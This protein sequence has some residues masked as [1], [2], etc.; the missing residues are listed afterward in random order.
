[1]VNLV[2]PPP[3]LQAD[4]LELYYV[5]DDLLSRSPILIFYG[6]AATPAASV[7]NNSR[8]QAHI[9]SPA[10][11]QSFHRLS[12][13]PGSPLYSAVQCLPRE[14]QGDEICRGLAFSLFKYFTELP[15][16]A[17]QAWE[18]QPT[19]LGSMRS[20]P[21]LF[22]DAHAGILASRMVRVENVAEVLGDVTQALAEQS[23][24]WLDLDI[25]L[26]PGTTKPLEMG[27]RDSILPQPSDEDIAGHRYGAYAPLIK[28]FGEVAFLPT[29]RLKRAPSKPTALNRK[30]TFT[31]EQ[32]EIV[33]RE[34]VDLLDSEERYVEKIGE[35]VHNVASDFREKARTKRVSSNS[36]NSDALQGLFPES[37]DKILETNNA[38]LEAMRPIVDNTVDE[39]IA[40]IE[41]TPEGGTVMPAVPTRADVTGTLAL[42]TCLRSWFPKFADCY[43]DYTL[44]HKQFTTHLRSFMK[45]SNSSFSR[46]IQDTGEQRLMSMLIEPVQR[47]PRYNLYIDNII[48]QLPARHPALNS[49]LK[50]RDTIAEICS[51]DHTIA[52]PSRVHDNLRAV[53]SAW[54][55]TFSPKGRL[56]SAVDIIELPPPYRPDLN[57][58]RSVPGILLLFTDYIVILRKNSKQSMTARGLL[59]QLDGTDVLASE[60]ADVMVD[61]LSFRQTLELNT[62]D[63]TEMDSG[64]MVQLVPLADTVK[65]PLGPRR[66]GSSRPASLSGESAVQVFYLSGT[67][68][69]KA[70]RLIEDLV[71]ARVEGRF[72]EEERDSHKWEARSATCAD[73][74]LLGALFEKEQD[75][76]PAGRGAPARVR[77]LI[78][79][80]PSPTL[81]EMAQTS[82]HGMDAIASLTAM[83]DGYYC[84]RVRQVGLAAST[85]TERL[86]AQECLPVLVTFCK[87]C[88]KMRCNIKHPAMAATFLLRNQHI[89]QSMR[90]LTEESHEHTV[91]ERASRPHSPVKML[92]NLFGGSVSRDHGSLRKHT[93]PIPQM[94]PTPASRP[95][96]EDGPAKAQP[97]SPTQVVHTAADALIRLEETLAS[98][99][100]ALD[101][102][103]GNI[104]GRILRGRASADELMVNELYNAL[105]EDPANYEIVAQSPIDVLFSAFEKF[106]KVAWYEKIG[107]IISRSTWNAIQSKMDTTYPGDFE[108][109]FR[110][111]YGEMSPQNQRALRACIKLLADLLGGTSNDSDRGVLT[112]SFAEVLVR[113]GNPNEFI[114]VLDR[115]VEDIQALLGEQGPSAQPTPQGSMNEGSRTQATNTGSL[116]S[117]TSLRKKFG[118]GTLTRKAS[119]LGQGDESE[120]GEKSEKTDLAS[121][122][123]AL[124]K[125]KHGGETSS[126]SKASMGNIGRS[127]STDVNARLSPKRP[128]SRDRPTVL[129]AFA[130]EHHNSPLTTIGEGQKAS[131]PPR[132]KRRSSVSDLRSLQNDISLTETPSFI[133]PR[134]PNKERLF[135]NDSPTTPS[136]TKPSF[137]PAPSPAGSPRR[138]LREGSPIRAVGGVSVPRPL[139]LSR[140]LTSTATSPLKPDEVTITTNST[141]T[142]RRKES[143]SVSGIPTFNSTI[144]SP[145]SGLSERPTSGNIRKLPPSPEKPSLSAAFSP[146]P[147]T[148]K[149]RM[150]SPQRLRE[151]LNNEKRAIQDAENALQAE[152]LK[153]S[154]EMKA[155]NASPTKPAGARPHYSRNHSSTAAT[156]PS[157]EAAKLQAQVTT[158]QTRL[159]SL[160]SDITSSLKVSENRL[161]GLDQLY[162]DSTAE[163]EI[164][165]SRF[166]EEIG[167]VISRV[168]LGEGEAEVR[169]R[170]KEAEDEAGRLRKENARLRRENV[171]LKAQL[172]E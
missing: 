90:I 2:A 116:T 9:F 95:T 83:D 108:E 128:I 26:P 51:H 165:Y 137:I 131:G 41:A 120:K 166:N 66:P 118:F 126:M 12:V 87:E 8:I 115:L 121:V 24:S 133:A 94:Y 91:K 163:N 150:Q 70:P 161:K 127:N 170:L 61:D 3:T 122:W 149:L 164:L 54:P 114:T 68:E 168:R 59:A 82:R 144:R 139:N 52:Q 62:F 80:P 145:P 142:R 69:G 154:D 27:G 135:S 101:A 84:L 46:R 157:Q 13:V 10:G 63:L 78:D 152:L 50:A 167:K 110:T 109:F 36:P 4:S 16:P 111:K 162:R 159:A 141:P 31:R 17:K 32:K 74:T 25:V 123:R 151:R 76:K 158:L 99:I 93:A 134:T 117:N 160:E 136:S 34:M 138:E 130:F 33:R 20:A 38:F 102:R 132:K 129:G 104:V 56:I 30:A 92:S 156:A 65:A 57:G 119:K 6:P 153:I 22:T 105:L 35:L 89:L 155:P 47:L 172:R 67:Y 60:R 43:L 146:P 106:V 112:A 77:I 81:D 88:I 124:S 29:S 11:F 79:P 143:N 73:L 171:G 1:M 140:P 71:R 75:G 28:L 85:K 97:N 98:Y 96:S 72:P 40:D 48:K 39:A 44:A 86:R 58:P 45:D 125:S 14:E 55:Q 5:V 169:K 21:T 18:A 103:K 49:L 107:P 15:L 64:K 42:A 53:V 7:A 23:L 100:L 113:E 147:T 148:G 19:A 37:L